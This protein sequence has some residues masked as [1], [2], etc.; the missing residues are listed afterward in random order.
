MVGGA[1]CVQKETGL[2]DSP[3][4]TIHSRYAVADDPK[5]RFL[6]GAAPWAS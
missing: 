3:A 2:K 5:K 4:L 6:A 1:E